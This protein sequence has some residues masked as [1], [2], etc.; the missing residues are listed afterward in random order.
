[1]RTHPAEKSRFILQLG[2]AEP[3]LALQ[4]ALTV[5][6]DVRGID[7]NCGCP[8]VFSTHAGMGAALLA[9][10]DRLVAILQRLV[11]GLA[12]LGVSVTAKIR[13]LPTLPETLDLVRR[14]KD[15]GVDGITV[16]C[17][18]PHERTNTHPSHWEWIPAIAKAI[19][20]LALA[21]N[22]DLLTR[23]AVQRALQL[24]GVSAVMLARGAQWNPTI[25]RLKNSHQSILSQLLCATQD[26]LGWAVRVD[27][28]FGNTKY[29]LLQLWIGQAKGCNDDLRSDNDLRRTAES[30]VVKLQSCKSYEQIYGVFN[31][32]VPFTSSAESSLLL[33]EVLDNA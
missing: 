16:H 13:L 14:I 5:H 21:A 25:F 27:N 26:Y 18:F 3:E 29:T 6:Q 17:R 33:E 20:P 24:E 22:G 1:M 32:K 2:S 31:W 19:H 10:P 4:A 28:W 7:L 11:T 23:E 9:Q 15:A 30:I 12:G 8:K